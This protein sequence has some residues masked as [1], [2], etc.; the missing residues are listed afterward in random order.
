MFYL[1][2]LVLLFPACWQHVCS[3]SAHSLYA[4][5]V[6]LLTVSAAMTKCSS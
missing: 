4:V 6:Q 3:S 1:A 5:I 2:V